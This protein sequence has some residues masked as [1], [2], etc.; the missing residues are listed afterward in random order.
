MKSGIYIIKNIVNGKRYVGSSHNIFVRM[1]KHLYRLRNGTH[2][3][4]DLQEEFS[5]LGEINFNISVLHYCPVVF[6]TLYE[7][8][9]QDALNPEYNTLKKAARHDTSEE[10]KAI[11]RDLN[12]GKVMSDSACRKMAIAK[13][14]TAHHCV[15]HSEESKKK[16]SDSKKGRP[17]PKRGTKMSEE[18]KA[19]MRVSRRAY[20]E[21]KRKD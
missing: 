14:G 1:H 15:P 13:I 12:L 5:T 21:R 17:S 4:R 20:L 10:T 16:M 18:S 11:L 7:Q 2:G 8:N 3:I 6:L 9:A 19:R